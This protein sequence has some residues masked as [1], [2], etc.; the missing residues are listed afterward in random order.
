MEI[1]GRI[2][3]LAGNLQ[4]FGN[5]LALRSSAEANHVMVRNREL[6]RFIA[7]GGIYTSRAKLDFNLLWKYV[8]SYE[9]TRFAGGTPPLPQPLGSY[10][11]LNL[12]AGWTFG[13]RPVNRIYL[14]MKNLANSNF[15]TVVGYP[16]FGRRFTIGVLSV[17]K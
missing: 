10:H 12:T 16:D 5:F 9:S 4:L 7:S 14:E 17:Y 8:S 3:Q 1:D 2:V 11:N 15:S 13:V 6:P